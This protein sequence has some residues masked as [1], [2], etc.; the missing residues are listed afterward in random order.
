MVHLRT[1][2]VAHSGTVAAST[3]TALA[4]GAVTSSL[5]LLGCWLAAGSRAMTGVVLTLA[6]VSLAIPGPIIGVGLTPLGRWMTDVTGSDLVG[7]LFYFGPSYLPPAW[8]CAV[9]FFGCAVVVLWPVVRMLP[10]DLRESARVDGA[11]TSQEFR[12]LIWP[13]TG[14][15]WLF[16]AWVVAALCLGEL[17]A[18]KIVATAG[19]PMLAHEVFGLMH[20]GVTNDLAALC[21]VLLATAAGTGGVAALIRRRLN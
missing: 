10:R 1:V 4:A 7:R 9:R 19:A 13:L 21:L 3:A 17:A 14:L 5:A 12:H 6:A 11:T 16:A 2:I 18:S 20:T 8:A 15:A